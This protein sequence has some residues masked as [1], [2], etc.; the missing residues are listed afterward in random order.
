MD[1]LYMTQPYYSTPANF[2]VPK[3]S[4]AKTPADLS[5]KD[6]G[7]CAGCTME[8][9]LRGTL[10]LPGPKLEQL[11]DGPR[12]VTFD[13]EV[14]GLVA[15]AKRKIDA[16]LCSEPVGAEAIAKG[17]PLR[18][19]ETP[20]YYSNKTGYVDKKSGLAV[21]PFVDKVNDIVAGLHADGTLGKLSVKYFGKDYAA[22]AAEFDLSAIDQTVQ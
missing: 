5:G 8:K 20:A 17:A 18:M 2:F 1:V 3:S 15:T 19:L 21:G 16:F 7:A 22:K 11:V 4:P 14:P 12:I 6:V 13:T 9:Y 10:E